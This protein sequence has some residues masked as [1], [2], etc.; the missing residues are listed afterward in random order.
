MSWILEA[1]MIAFRIIFEL[2]KGE[3]AYVRDLENIEMVSPLNYFVG[4]GSLGL[5][6]T[7]DL[8][9]TLNPQSFPLIVWTNS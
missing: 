2:I 5:R 7:F 8:S 1:F 6:Y 4:P 9:A 3:M